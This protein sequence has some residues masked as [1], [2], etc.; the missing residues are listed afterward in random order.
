[1]FKCKVASQCL[2]R[3]FER[4][5]KT[6]DAHKRTSGNIKDDL[7]ASDVESRI[8]RRSGC[9]NREFQ[10][11]DSEREARDICHYRCTHRTRNTGRREQ[12]R[13]AS[14]REAHKI[15]RAVAEG[16]AHVGCGDS[17]RTGGCAAGDFVEGEVSA[18]LLADD[19]EVHVESLE[20]RYIRN[21]REVER[22]A[23]GGVRD[24]ERFADDASR[25]VHLHSCRSAE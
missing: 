17:Q 25:V 23:V 8:N 6:N 16:N 5:A 12:E 1:M 19:V 18:E 22:D 9:I 21:R 4:N 13:A 7:R 2:A 15:R 14:V 11:G 3:N 10:R 20:L 24:G